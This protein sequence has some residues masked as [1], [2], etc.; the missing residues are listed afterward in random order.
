MFVLGANAAG[1]LNKLESFY[2]NISTFNPGVI[3]IQES[4]ARR[5]GK[6]KLNN[7]TIFEKIRKQ[8]NGG[9]LLTAVHSSLKPVSISDDD[10]EILVVEANINNSMVRLINGYGPQENLPENSRKL[11]FDQLDLE[12][13]KAKIAGTLVCIE[14]DSNA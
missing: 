4:K 6:I 13:K 5:K 9:G 11:F 14:M 10:E 2:R 12:V 8:N 7:Y 1:L 3:F